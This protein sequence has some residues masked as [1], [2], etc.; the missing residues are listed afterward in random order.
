MLV[1]VT[2]PDG[3][4]FSNDTGVSLPTGSS[5]SVI[6]PATQVVV[7]NAVIGGYECGFVFPEGLFYT[8]SGDLEVEITS[9][10]ISR[11]ATTIQ[12][13]NFPSGF[14]DTDVQITA[15]FGFGS[16]TGPVLP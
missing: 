8:G 16:T 5:G 9:D 11:D 12:C 15:D 7:P 4:L 6:I 1:F 3:K 10:N 14:F 13:V 2:T